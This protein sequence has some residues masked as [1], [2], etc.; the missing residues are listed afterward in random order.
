MEG[1]PM[2]NQEPKSTLRG[3]DAELTIRHHELWAEPA[4]P[5]ESGYPEEQGYESYADYDELYGP[6]A[7]MGDQFPLGMSG[8]IETAASLP[9][10][11]AVP[12]ELGEDIRQE[13]GLESEEIGS[14]SLTALEEEA[15]LANRSLPET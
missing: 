12:V 6:D 9:I 14:E 4:L 7:F 10:L 5:Q 8:P 2:P 1:H 15:L 13:K 11:P 3:K